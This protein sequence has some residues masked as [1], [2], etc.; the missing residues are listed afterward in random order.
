[1]CRENFVQHYR[2]IVVIRCNFKHFNN[3]LHSEILLILI[4]KMKYLTDQFQL[5]FHFALATL[6]SSDAVETIT[7]QTE[8]SLKLRDPV[9][10][11][12]ETETRAPTWGSAAPG[13]VEKCCPPS[14]A[15]QDEII[16]QQCIIRLDLIL[17]ISLK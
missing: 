7:F 1:M 11:I 8:T 16:S 15:F 4:R 14:Q 13:P 3:I 2:K 10:K 6:Y 5:S 12:S 9:F 17:K